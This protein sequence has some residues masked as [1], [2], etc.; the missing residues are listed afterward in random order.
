[1]MLDEPLVAELIPTQRPTNSGTSTSAW[2][3]AARLARREVRRRPG[4][5]ALA[6]LLIAV[7]VFAMTIGSVMV[8]SERDDWASH[9]HRTYGNADVAS[10]RVEFLAAPATSGSPV[11]D[12]NQNELPA[13]SRVVEFVRVEA[14]V[15]PSVPVVDALPWASFSDIPLNDPLTSGIVE[16]LDGDAPGPGEVL[17]G[18]KLAKALGLE[19]GDRLELAR[20]SGTWTVS[21]IGRYSDSYW[22]EPM[23]INGF[24]RN[25]LRLVG[26]NQNAQFNTPNVVQLFDLPDGLS[27]VEVGQVAESMGAM[28]ANDKKVWWFGGGSGSGSGQALAWGW[29][30]GALALIAVGIIVAAAFATSARRQLVTVGQLS[31]NGATSAVIRRTLSLQGTWTA[32]IGAVVGIGVGLASLPFLRGLMSE[33]IVYRAVNYRISLLDLIGIAA[34]AVIVGTFAA[35]VPARSTSRIPVM[36]ALAGRRPLATPPAW[37]VPT[38]VGLFGG[39]VGLI[40]VAAAGARNSGSG[41]LWAFLIVLGGVGVAFGMCCATPL[42]VERIGR[43]GRRLP[44]AWRMSVRSLARSRTRS[45]AVVAAIAVAVGGA[46]AGATIAEVTVGS[47]YQYVR[48]VPLDTVVLSADREVACCEGVVD[49]G[50]MPPLTV[51]QVALDRLAEVFPSAVVTPLRVATFDPAPVDWASP[52]IDASGGYSPGVVVGPW[53]ADPAVLDLIGLSRADLMTLRSEGALRL[54]PVSAASGDEIANGM[55]RYTTESGVIDLSFHSTHANPDAIPT[56]V[57]ITPEHAAE[58]GFE[59]VEFGAVIRN[60]RD[61]TTAQR[62]ALNTLHVLLNGQPQS[63]DSFV[64]PGDPVI[65]RNTPSET[66]DYWSV[67]FEYPIDVSRYIW[68]ARAII[69]AA[70]LLLSVMV[71]AI[72]LSLAAAEGRDERDVLAVVGARPS[73]LRR[74]A[75]TKA[76]TLSLTGVALGVATGFIPVWVLYHTINEASAIP[77]RFPWLVAVLLVLLVPGLAGLMAWAGSGIAQRLK[78]IRIS[79]QRLD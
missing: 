1:M 27:P 25:R 21:G 66:T 67:R 50:P 70:A 40:A 52:N 63:I 36:A 19:V 57:V 20:P 58:L 72:G 65:A 22:S 33:H 79:T 45:A 59:I 54:W 76:A 51:P 16:F 39:G 74:L 37:L 48:S 24:D 64:E 29:V 2:R 60:D 17:L 61:L 7:P 14:S 32:C 34:T 6:A 41:D 11:D 10:E 35:R 12:T 23:I 73:M 75:G 4:R 47:Q 31:S 26:E 78:P 28:T 56:D 77:P 18:P 68:I 62:D 8:R 13:G 53:I 43:T 55:V 30:A 9:F 49:V 3:L 44:L 15:T 5:T 69:T 38:G 42:V 71:V 46:V